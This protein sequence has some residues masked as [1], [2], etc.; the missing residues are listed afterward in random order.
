MYLVFLRIQL[1]FIQV[2]LQYLLIT[3]KNFLKIPLINFFIITTV[4]ENLISV[5]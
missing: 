1:R 5:I 3:L 4:G 2:L